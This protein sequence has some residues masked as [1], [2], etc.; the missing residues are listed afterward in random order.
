MWKPGHSRTRS[1]AGLNPIVTI[2]IRH[3]VKVREIFAHGQAPGDGGR[4][5]RGGRDHGYSA[6]IIR[7]KLP[8]NCCQ[9]M[10]VGLFCANNGWQKRTPDCPECREG[11]GEVMRDED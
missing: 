4:G 2:A 1:I 9:N 10:F 8:I 6:V 3:R 11:R 5:A 7:Y